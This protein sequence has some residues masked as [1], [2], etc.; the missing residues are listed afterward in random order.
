LAQVGG[1]PLQAAADRRLMDAQQ[2]S[3]TGLLGA[4]LQTA[5]WLWLA[6]NAGYPLGVLFYVLLKDE[7]PGPA[8]HRSSHTAIA[9]SVAIVIA[10]VLALTW[11]GTAGESHLPKIVP[12]DSQSSANLRHVG[13]LLLL[14]DAAV[15]ALLW[16]RR[17]SVLDLWLSVAMC[18]WL[19]QGI[20]AWINSAGRFGLS[21][22]AAGWLFATSSTV[23]LLCY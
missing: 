17:R 9:A 14:V 16:S 1:Q 19:A 12:L 15:L 23:L 21:Y 4:G 22:Y 8:Q 7:T 11:I 10:V 3:P 20:A 5:A 2:F 6:S 13:T 18:A